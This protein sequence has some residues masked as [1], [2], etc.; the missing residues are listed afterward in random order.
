MQLLSVNPFS[1]ESLSRWDVHSDREIEERLSASRTWQMNW[2]AHSVANRAVV[3]HRL[4]K[5]LNEQVEPLSRMM[6]L[7]MGKPLLQGRA[8]VRKCVWCCIYFAEHAKSMLTPRR[9]ETDAR[10]SEVHFDPMGVWLAVMPWNY[11]FWQVIRCLVPAAMAGNTVVLKHASNVTGCASLLEEIVQEAAGGPLL[12]VLRLPGDRVA[13]VISHPAIRGV[14]FTGSEH[15]GRRVAAMAGGHLKPCVL[16]LGGSNAFIVLSDADPVRAAHEA[17][18]ARFQNSGQSCIA[19]K[20]ILI[21]EQ[22]AEIFTA[23]FLEKMGSLQSG[24]PLVERTDLG[25]LAKPSFAEELHDQVERCVN[26]GARIL[27]GG[28]RCEAF[29][30]PTALVV[31]G[32]ENPGMQE[33]LFGPVAVLCTASDTDALIALSNQS[34]FGLGVT[35]FT[36]NPDAAA[37]LIHRFDEGSIF[38]NSMVK[39]DPRLPFGGVKNSGFGR[40]LSIEG[41]ME[42]TN[43]KTL[44]I[45]D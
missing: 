13:E 33:E 6:A 20:R 21:D 10:R 39:S 7:E 11:P 31:D 38:I 3:L 5:L 9:V 42:F 22:I 17:V 27:A 26:A 16:E 2:A 14:S 12:T 29:Y 8:E 28:T 40:E 30:S 25:P 23:A 37:S 15:T 18:A 34:R 41:L 1:G 45:K 36:G 19:A 32:S 43:I 4:S 24:D 35:L 44:Y